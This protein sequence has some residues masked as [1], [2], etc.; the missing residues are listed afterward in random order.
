ME[1]TWYRG[2]RYTCT[3][4]LRHSVKSEG[5]SGTCTCI[6][7]VTDGRLGLNFGKVVM[8][9]ERRVCSTLYSTFKYS[10]LKCA[11]RV[12]ELQCKCTSGSFNSCNVELYKIMRT[13]T[14]L[15][16]RNGLAS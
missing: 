14:V 16:A 6:L 8:V 1:N 7:H 3:C 13:V 5:S 10:D 15:I 9:W 4:L 11:C 12:H 2:W